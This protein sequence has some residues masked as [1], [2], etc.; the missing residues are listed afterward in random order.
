MILLPP[1]SSRVVPRASCWDEEVEELCWAGVIL[2]SN[3]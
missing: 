2:V 3:A 1:G